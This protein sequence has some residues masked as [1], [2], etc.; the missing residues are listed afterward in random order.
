[1]HTRPVIV[2]SMSPFAARSGRLSRPTPP[3]PVR[4]RPVTGLALAAL[5]L[6]G[7]L[8]AA[9]SARKGPYVTAVSDSDATIRF[10]L[11]TAAPAV[12]E[13][14]A[15]PSG[16]GDASAKRPSR[17][18]SPEVSAMHR[19]HVTGLQPATSY[20]FVVRVGGSAVADGHVVTAPRPDS[21]APLTFLVY[22]DNRT[23]DA[24][25]ASVVRAMNAVPSDF[26][27]NTGDMIE[28]G[29]S[30]ANWQTFFDIERSLLHDRPLFA[31]I[32]NHELH[33]D[34]A[35]ANFERYFGFPE[36]SGASMPYGTVRFGSARFFFLNGMD[37][38]SSS[39]E[40][41]WLEQALSS[42]DTEAGLQWRFV[43]LHHGPWSSGPHGPNLKLVAAG[44][45]QLLTQHS[46]DLLLAGHDHL[47]ERGM[48]GALKYIVSGGGGAPLYRD[49][50]E[51]ATS[52]KVEPAH[53]FV[54]VTTQDST[55]RIVAMRDD[56]SVLDRC[57]FS[58]GK[59]WDCDA[60]ASV[61]PSDVPAATPPASSGAAAGA[62]RGCVCGEPGAPAHSG[63]AAL[64]ILAAVSLAKARRRG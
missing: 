8:H 45:V 41:Q 43:V 61:P 37:D 46:V 42:A 48:G 18:G 21:G 5:A 1:M 56:G 63:A 58:R 49:L 51:V 40:R 28:D 19:V 57:G 36:A 11:D 38:W 9:Q 3:R 22:G 54:Q 4:W 53:H 2:P 15:Q 20:A 10:E 24:A 64:A 16:A 26:L 60:P 31:A 52:R 30:A 59:P 23:D 27:V 32:G 44:V 12:I 39:P 34:A 35:G 50:H 13:V 47:Y 62:S 33:D 7:P 29:A 6:S 25:H 55:L 17:F 14:T